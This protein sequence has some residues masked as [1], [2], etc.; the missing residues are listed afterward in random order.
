MVD[1]LSHSHSSQ[2]S[3]TGVTKAVVCANLSGVVHIKEPLLLI[4]KTSLCGS[5]FSHSL[6][7]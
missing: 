6:S 2:C 4:R 3:M 1:P 7:E 5:E